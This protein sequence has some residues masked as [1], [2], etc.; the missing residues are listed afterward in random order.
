MVNADILH[1]LEPVAHILPMRIVQYLLT[2]LDTFHFAQFHAYFEAGAKAEVLFIEKYENLY[3]ELLGS[4]PDDHDEILLEYD[5]KLRFICKRYWAG[6]LNLALRQQNENQTYLV[7]ELSTKV[8]PYIVDF[9]FCR[10]V[11]RNATLKHL[12]R[13]SN[14]ETLT[15]KSSD[16]KWLDQFFSIAKMCHFLQQIKFE[17]IWCSNNFLALLQ[18]FLTFQVSTNKSVILSFCDFHSNNI[19]VDKW[20]LQLGDAMNG[21][22]GIQISH[23]SIFQ[24]NKQ[25]LFTYSTA[26]QMKEFSLC[27]SHHVST[28]LLDLVKNAPKKNLDHALSTLALSKVKLDV[29]SF[30][31]FRHWRYS[32]IKSISMIKVHLGYHGVLV[33]AENATFWPIVKKVVL[34]DC[35]IS[36][37]GFLHLFRAMIDDR[38]CENLVVL[39]ISN[40]PVRKTAFNILGTFLR[41][42]NIANLKVIRMCHLFT[43]VA[44]APSS[45]LSGIRSINL[46][47]LNM[48]GNKIDH[49]SIHR[50]L[51]S[52]LDR[53]DSNL[54][55]LTIGSQTY[56]YDTIQQLKQY[57]HQLGNKSNLS[58]LLSNEITTLYGKILC[59]QTE[60]FLNSVDAEN[61]N[62]FNLG[63]LD[64]SD[65]D[66]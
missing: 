27:G 22:A 55:Q 45:F 64:E 2:I 37:R 33:L 24:K 39:D 41:S 44:S 66:Y 59:L 12:S 16:P 60:K 13:F 50:I 3:K 48:Q 63:I 29:S 15:C 58:C 57:I 38:G 4:L 9:K 28:L 49:R 30:K 42:K 61:S 53:S 14:I 18:D 7:W 62:R 56:E 54:Q 34:N 26:Y 52:L 19:N 43:K 17:S 46:V 36:S 10:G 8:A 23:S 6:R 32:Q 47:K 11:A 31:A 20:F 25:W 5:T 51:Y 40:N 35:K 21:I 65:S 1:A